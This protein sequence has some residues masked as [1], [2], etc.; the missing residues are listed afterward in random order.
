MRRA[1]HSPPRTPFGTNLLHS[2]VDVVVVAQL[3]GHRRLDTTRLVS[4]L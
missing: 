2:G 1:S 4:G 3:M